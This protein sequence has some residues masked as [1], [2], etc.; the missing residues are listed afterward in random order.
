[1]TGQQDETS[2]NRKYSYHDSRSRPGYVCGSA[3]QT[4]GLSSQ[5][6][7]GIPAGNVE[8]PNALY[9]GHVSGMSG[10]YNMLGVSSMLF[11]PVRKCSVFVF[12]I[13]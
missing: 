4:S 12:E 9:T 5:T 13:C 1:M 7:L 6:A 11:I 2:Y 8:T 10:G 3:S